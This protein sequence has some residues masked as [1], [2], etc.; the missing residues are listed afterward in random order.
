MSF[1]TVSTHFPLEWNGG[2]FTS[3]TPNKL[4]TAK[5]HLALTLPE[6]L[7]QYESLQDGLCDIARNLKFKRVSNQ[8]KKI[9][10][11]QCLSYLLGSLLLDFIGWNLR[12]QWKMIIKLEWFQY[13]LMNLNNTLTKRILSWYF[14]PL[15]IPIQIY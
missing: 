7:H 3:S 2:H 13:H 6:P 12:L 15:P 8:L 5:K 14:W 9:S 4:E 11:C 10:R 1:Y